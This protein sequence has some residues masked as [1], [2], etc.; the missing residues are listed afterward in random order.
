MT[1]PLHRPSE[2][3]RLSRLTPIAVAFDRAL[4]NFAQDLTTLARDL[5]AFR[6]DL[7]TLV[8]ELEAVN[9]EMRH[10]LEEETTR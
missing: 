1:A 6:Q 7:R 5:S 3:S 9:R 2:G 4:K 10:R 8:E